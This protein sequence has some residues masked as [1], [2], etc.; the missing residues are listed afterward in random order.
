MSENSADTPEPDSI[1]ALRHD[2]TELSSRT[3]SRHRYLTREINALG[4][5]VVLMLAGGIIVAIVGALWSGSSPT[6]ADDDL[7]QLLAPGTHCYRSSEEMAAARQRALAAIDR[8]QWDRDHRSSDDTEHGPYYSPPA[9]TQAPPALPSIV[10]AKDPGVPQPG[11]NQNVD[12][13]LCFG[14]PKRVG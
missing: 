11:D 8:L 2:L 14:I 5:L 6:T 3:T 10:G 4:I 13:D 9:L 12:T 1:E 7:D